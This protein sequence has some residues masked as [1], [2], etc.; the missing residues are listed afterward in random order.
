LNW[1]TKE[2]P[3]LFFGHAPYASSF[4]LFFFIN[5][6]TFKGRAIDK[7]K[8]DF[9]FYPSRELQAKGFKEPLLLILSSFNL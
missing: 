1:L 9:H 4:P 2:I 7:G 3:V 8:K 5:C 6:P